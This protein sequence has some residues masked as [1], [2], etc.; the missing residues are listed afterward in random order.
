MELA[1]A[2]AGPPGP[3]PAGRPWR[4]GMGKREKQD[5]EEGVRRGAGPWREGRGGRGAGPQ[6]TLPRT[7]TAW[8]TLQ[9]LV[10]APPSVMRR[11][12]WT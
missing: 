5:E 6:T 4:R 2:P 12:A 9:K 8:P 3:W 1:L 7:V 10:W 11:W